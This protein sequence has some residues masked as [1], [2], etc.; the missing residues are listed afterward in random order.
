MA[1]KR[2]SLCGEPATHY[3]ASRPAGSAAPKGEG[4]G[5]P[6]PTLYCPY[7]APHHASPLSPSRPRTPAAGAGPGW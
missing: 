4:T 3:T 7:C 1:D 6:G 2:C 5:E